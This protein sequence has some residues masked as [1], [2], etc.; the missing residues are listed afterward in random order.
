MV[1]PLISSPTINHL[2]HFIHPISVYDHIIS[3]LHQLLS[4]MYPM[5]QVL[6]YRYPFQKHIKYNTLKTIASFPK[7]MPAKPRQLPIKL[8]RN[9]RN[10]SWNEKEPK[11]N[12]GTQKKKRDKNQQK[13]ITTTVF[14]RQNKTKNRKKPT[15]YNSYRGLK[16]FSFF[17]KI[18]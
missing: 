11:L 14:L 7:C 2:S 17:F 16:F 1:I 9:G 13:Q 15:K 18:S 10:G 4:K 6:F 5:N 8:T 3:T 12:C